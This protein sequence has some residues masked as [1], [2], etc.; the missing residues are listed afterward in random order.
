[1]YGYRC[2]ICGDVIYIDPGEERVCDRCMDERDRR[3]RVAK[4]YAGAIRLN[5]NQ[6]EMNMEGIR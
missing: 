1:M 6:Y 2:D 5:D 4:R 3:H